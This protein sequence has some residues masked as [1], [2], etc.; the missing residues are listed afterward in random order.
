MT[1]LIVSVTIGMILLAVFPPIS[2]FTAILVYFLLTMN[3]K[4]SEGL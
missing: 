2:P 1:S 4:N 3:D